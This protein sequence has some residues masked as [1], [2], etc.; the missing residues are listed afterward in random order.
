MCLESVTHG[1]KSHHVTGRPRYKAKAEVLGKNALVADFRHG[2]WHH[3][4]FN[5][6]SEVAK[7]YPELP[8]EIVAKLA[9]LFA[10]HP[11][12]SVVNDLRRMEEIAFKLGEYDS[13]GLSSEDFTA[14]FF[15]RQLQDILAMPAQEAVT[16]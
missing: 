3:E 14:L 8:E 2:Q 5:I 13:S 15:L 12:R 4:P 7:E 6:M 9:D 11:R 1:F 10:M 16:C